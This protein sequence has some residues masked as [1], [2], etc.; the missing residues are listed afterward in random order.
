MLRAYLP[1]PSLTFRTLEDLQIYTVP[2]TAS[3]EVHPELMINA[4]QPLCRATLSAEL[5]SA[6]RRALCRY[7]GLSYTENRGDEEIA[8]DGFVR[9]KEGG[10]YAGCRFKTSPVMFLNV[11]I[12][13]LRRDRMGIEKTHMGKILAGE[14]LTEKDFP[15]EEA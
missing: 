15:E 4:A 9:R 1:R 6:L 8:A 7:L 11:L 2:A 10:E 13:K 12:Q 3:D 14:I 5:L